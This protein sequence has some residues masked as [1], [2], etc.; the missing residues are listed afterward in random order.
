VTRERRRRAV[1]RHELSHLLGLAPRRGRISRAALRRP[2]VRLPPCAGRDAMQARTARGLRSRRSSKLPSPN[3]TP[4]NAKALKAGT[5][6][7]GG[8][9]GGGAVARRLPMRRS[10]TLKIIVCR[11]PPDIKECRQAWRRARTRTRRWRLAARARR[12]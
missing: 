2:R 9:C 8:G 6:R 7:D 10:T 11:L 3:S 4:P 1:R 5:T 12:A